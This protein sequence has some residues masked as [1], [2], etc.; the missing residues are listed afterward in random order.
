MLRVPCKPC[1]HTTGL[2][3]ALCA[4]RGNAGESIDP[5]AFNGSFKAQLAV[6]RTSDCKPAAL[7]K[8]QGIVRFYRPGRFE[9]HLTAQ[10]VVAL[11]SLL[12]LKPIRPSVTVLPGKADTAKP[13]MAAL[14]KPTMAQQPSASCKVSQS[15]LAKTDLQSSAATDLKPTATESTQSGAL[16]KAPRI[17]AAVSN[18][19]AAERA[20]DSGT[21]QP[22]AFQMNG[23]KK[24][25]GSAAGGAQ[26]KRR[27]SLA[28]VLDDV[29][30]EVL[31]TPRSRKKRRRLPSGQLAVPSEQ[32]LQPI[33]LTASPG[34]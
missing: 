7:S 26:H 3:T 23:L 29:F 33:D 21:S 30:E 25:S 1:M 17:A 4:H 31:S 16:Q 8:I 11:S 13:S 5:T 19:I 2:D 6:Q 24:K 9:Q 32:L 18:G 10:Q 20:K 14:P 34:K 27:L 15:A 12:S 28:A 22:F